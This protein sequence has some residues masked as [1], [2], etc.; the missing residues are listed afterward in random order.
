MA[1]KRLFWQDPYQTEYEATITKIEQN[2]LYLD[3]TVF[4]AFSGGQ[5]SDQGTIGEIKVLSA[6]DEGEEISYELEQNSFKVG[7]KVLVNINQEFRNRVMRLH[8][9]VHLV[10]FISRKYLGEKVQI[11]GS[12]VTDQK[13]RI[14]YLYEQN[15]SDKLPQ[16]QQEVE[17]IIKENLPIITKGE[18]NNQN[19]RIWL[20]EKYDWK[21]PCAGTH[22]RTTGEIGNIKLKRE[23]IGKGKER[24]SVILV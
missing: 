2:K 14:D 24:I 13:S 5:I 22:P 8:S 12:N 16:I 6:T 11:I 9:A 19:H 23:N 15:I 20:I 17:Q 3:Q 1:T 18:E 7:D 4:F 21:M 10:D